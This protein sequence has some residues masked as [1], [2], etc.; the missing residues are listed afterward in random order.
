MAEGLRALCVQCQKPLCGA[1][2][3][4][5]CNH[6]FHKSCFVAGAACG[7][8]GDIL[9]H[10]SSLSLYNLCCDDQS[11]YAADVMAAAAKLK[12]SLECLEDPDAAIFDPDFVVQDS[13]SGS[14]EDVALLCLK[15]ERVKFKRDELDAQ[16]SK[17]HE[18]SERVEHQK[19][20]LRAREKIA[21]GLE[22]DHAKKKKEIQ[23]RYEEHEKML[24]EC[25]EARQR[26]T[27]LEYWDLL[28]HGQEEEA[29]QKLT[30]LIG[31][32][33]HPWKTL[34]HLARLRDHFRKL[35]DV[36]DRARAQADA[37]LQ[38]C[39]RERAD[40]EQTK[41][42]LERQLSKRKAEG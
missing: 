18:A 12:A 7:R 6:V 36:H 34:A 9:R 22:E 20:K 4:S 31:M 19:K 17:L 21:Q 40:L 14:V 39:N 13:Q 42:E 33:S 26:T 2:L 28:R 5:G 25:N 41:D 38:H 1:V 29:L 15:R 23:L 10:E 3:A 32:I 11:E 24:A 27:I 30:T 16:Q 35:C 8:C 37:K